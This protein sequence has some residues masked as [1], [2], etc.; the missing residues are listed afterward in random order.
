MIK[1]TRPKH[2]DL[3]A[4]GFIGIGRSMTEEETRLASEQI[5]T[6]KAKHPSPKRKPAKRGTS[7]KR[8]RYAVKSLPKMAKGA[9]AKLKSLDDIGF[10]GGPPVPR[11][12]A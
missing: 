10:I 8:M 9:D 11:C 5:Q 1:K 2:L 12:S 3:D 7:D 4:I 6:Y